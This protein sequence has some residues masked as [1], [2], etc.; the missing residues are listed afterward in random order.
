MPSGSTTSD[1]SVQRA[2]SADPYRKIVEHLG[3][4]RT[5]DVSAVEAERI[6]ATVAMIPAD[7]GTVID[8]GCGDGRI[9]ERLP[10]RLKSIGVDYSHRSVG[11]LAGAGLCAS[12][13]DLPF[14]D[15]SFD[16]AL[17]CEVLEHLPDGMFQR[18][19]RE[20]G[21]IARGYVLISVPYKEDLRLRRTRCNEC[22]AMFHVWGHVRRF[23]NRRLKG[24]LDGFVVASTRYVGKR[25]P[26]HFPVVV[27]LNQ[28][29]GGRWAEWERTSICLQ[30]GNTVFQRAPRN[31]I[32]MACGLINLLTARAVP[33]S[34]KNWIV[35]LYTRRG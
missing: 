5:R 28:R 30:C 27:A 19:L 1:G 2:R 12:S 6:E 22:G 26:C 16:L 9:L 24:L 23:T 8:V 35:A 14:A 13:E 25:A 29:Y 33:V 10:R 31:A 3:A 20:L 17:C 32:T 4:E 7:V 15:R 18:T 34:R 21:R 11:E